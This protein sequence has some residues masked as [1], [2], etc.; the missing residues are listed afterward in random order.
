MF[1]NQDARIIFVF[2]YAEQARMVLCEVSLN[3]HKL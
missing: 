1:Q 2:M 3:W